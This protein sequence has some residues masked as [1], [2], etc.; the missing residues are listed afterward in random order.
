LT[1][2]YPD[3]SLSIAYHGTVTGDPDVDV[4][5]SGEFSAGLY[6]SEWTG[7][8]MGET[9]F[10]V[11]LEGQLQLGASIPVAGIISAEFSAEK[12][13]VD[14]TLTL[15]TGVAAG[16][17]KIGIVNFTLA[18]AVLGYR[19]FQDSGTSESFWQAS[20]LWLSTGEQLADGGKHDNPEGGV[21]IHSRTEI[22]IVPVPEPCT[23]LLL[24]T[25][26]AGIGV[27]RRSVSGKHTRMTP[28]RHRSQC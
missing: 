17:L 27:L 14:R 1:G 3:G 10:G 18:E 28:P 13:L 15:T 12:D 22:R 23:C 26:L 6:S 21:P 24:V 16:Q 2:T 25:G 5:A 9:S 4:S 19:I 7:A 8:I 20:A 11:G